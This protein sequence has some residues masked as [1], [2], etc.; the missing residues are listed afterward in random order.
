M[1]RLAIVFV[2]LGL[3]VS[4][5]SYAQQMPTWD[6]SR[7]LQISFTQGS[8]RVWYFMESESPVHDP[9]TYRLSQRYLNPC[10]SPN[11]GR[12]GVFAGVGCWQGT[13]FPLPPDNRGFCCGLK[14]EIA[15][16]FTNQVIGGGAVGYMEPPGYLA[17]VV[18]LVGSD[19]LAIV[20][21]QSPLSGTVKVTARFKWRNFLTAAS[22]N[23]FVDKGN[24]T[25]ASD[26]IGVGNEDSM[27]FNSAVQMIKGDVLYF[28]V[29]ASGYASQYVYMP[30]DLRVTI[31]Q[32]Q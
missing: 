20:A 9:S 18:R 21:W 22:V 1:K 13:E 27:S 15:F 17:H 5:N 24:Q 4:V 14:S 3:F 8:D 25:L 7:D 11:Q 16:N 6:L 28:I 31:T 10:Q 12:G 29:D 30:V 23:C 2:S 19:R 32:V 26:W